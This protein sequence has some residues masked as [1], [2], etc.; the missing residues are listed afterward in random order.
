MTQLHRSLWFYLSSFIVIY[1]L[2]QVA[3]TVLV[4]QYGIKEA[5]NLFI[6][7]GLPVVLVSLIFVRNEHKAPTGSVYW[8]LF[9]GSLSISIPISMMVRSYLLSGSEHAGSI[10]PFPSFAGDEMG[11]FFIIDLVI[12]ALAFG[13]G[14]GFFARLLSDAQN[15]SQEPK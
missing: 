9:V 14:Y 3:V 11:L 7:L 5:G 12:R 10:S 13:I 8:G 2:V 6:E 15:R 4:F 1:T